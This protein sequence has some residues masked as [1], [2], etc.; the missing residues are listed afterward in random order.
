[1]LL[2]R[3]VYLL[4]DSTLETYALEAILMNE[5]SLAL[6][7]I[8]FSYLLIFS[9]KFFEAEFWPFTSLFVMAFTSISF[10]SILLLPILTNMLQRRILS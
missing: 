7:D 2:L 8:C 4:A 5:L 1:M 6:G 10:T 3:E 9:W